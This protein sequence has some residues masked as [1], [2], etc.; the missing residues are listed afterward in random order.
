MGGEGELVQALGSKGKDGSRSSNGLSNLDQC[1]SIV[2]ERRNLKSKKM[3]SCRGPQVNRDR[4]R[5]EHVT[6]DRLRR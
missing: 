2:R 6:V 1:L 4:V 3:Q 5:K